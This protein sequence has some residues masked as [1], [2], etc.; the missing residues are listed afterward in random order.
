MACPAVPYF[1]T[2]SHKRHDF[3][4]KVTEHKMCVLIFCTTFAWDTSH[5]KK[6][7]ARCD[8]KYAQ[9]FMKSPPLFFSNINQNWI[10]LR[11]IRKIGKYQIHEN[12]SIGIRVFFLGSDKRTDRLTDMK[13]LTVA[14]LPE[15]RA[16]YGI[17]W[18]NSAQQDRPQMA[19][20]RMRVARWIT[21]AT[22]IYSEYA[23]L[24]VFPLQQWVCGGASMWRHKHIAY[25]LICSQIRISL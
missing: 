13:K 17:M 10:F 23:I 8:R 1:S 20:W 2:L 11:D 19:I 24:I 14:S 16:V 9:V 25:L 21:K 6:N 12:S 7:W 22:N 4:G 5:C 15:N 18:K 3:S